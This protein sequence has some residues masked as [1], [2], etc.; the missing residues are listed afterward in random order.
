MGKM[1]GLR[2][3]ENVFDWNELSEEIQKL[4]QN[5]PCNKEQHIWSTSNDNIIYCKKCGEFNP[6]TYLYMKNLGI[7]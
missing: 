7:F 2:E 4:K 3:G 6:M 1:D 5:P